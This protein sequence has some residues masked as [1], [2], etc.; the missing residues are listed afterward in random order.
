VNPVSYISL[1]TWRRI[2]LFILV[3]SILFWIAG[4]FVFIPFIF[5]LLSVIEVLFELSIK[6]SNQEWQNTEEGK[7]WVRRMINAGRLFFIPTKVMMF[8]IAL[9]LLITG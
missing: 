3:I 7:V 2:D 1:D 4:R 8:L 6:R 9:F 5:I